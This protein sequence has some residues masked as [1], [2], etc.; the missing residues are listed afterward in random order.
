MTAA[1]DSATGTTY[2][3]TGNPVPAPGTW[4][5]PNAESRPGANLYSNT[6]LALDGR[7]GRLR[8]YNQVLP[9]DL[10]HHDFQNPPVLAVGGDKKLVIG[11]GKMGI[12]YAIDRAS[13]KLVWKRPVGTHQNDKL[14]RLP[15]GKVVTVY[16]GFWGGNE[17]PASLADGVLYVLTVNMP[18]PYTANAWGA[19]D[20][21]HAVHNLEGRTKYAD[22]TSEVDAIDVATGKIRWTRRLPT[23]GFAATTVVND[24]IFTATYDGKIYALSRSDGQIVWTHQAPGGIIAWPAVAGDTIIWPVGLGRNPMLLALRLGAKLP[25]AQPRARPQASPPPK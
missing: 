17:T 15:L 24:L 9:H 6:L 13:G 3:S 23:V 12:V 4:R 18:T 10:F 20:G 25:I 14:Q 8:W 19:R 11:T 7:T 1:I 16:P 2:W 22:G 5:H 21:E